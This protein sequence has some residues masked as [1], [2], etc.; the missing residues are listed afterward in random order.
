MKK[1]AII[2]VCYFI[3]NI[4]VKFCG[5]ARELNVRWFDSLIPGGNKAHV[6]LTCK[7]K[8]SRNLR[9]PLK[10]IELN[11]RHKCCMEFDDGLTV[12]TVNKMRLVMI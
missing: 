5:S 11:T 9:C 1:A 10:K 3:S 6:A 2:I 7:M 4:Y 8:Q 12:F